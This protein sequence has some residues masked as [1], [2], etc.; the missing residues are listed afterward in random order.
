MDMTPQAWPDWYDGRHINEVLFCQQFLDKHPMKCVRGRLFTVDG[1]IEDEGQ[2]GNLILEEISG[3]LTSGLSKV[4][5]N[6][7][8]SIKLQAY[9]PPLPIEADRIHVANGTYFMDGSF[10][11]NKSYCNNRLTVSYNPD[12]PTPKRWLQFL[13]ELLQPEDIPTLQEFWVTVCCR[14]PRGRRCSCSSARAA[15]AKAASVL[16]CACYARQQTRGIRVASRTCR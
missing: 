16:S 13:S 5:T 2:I 11:P 3:V 4:V 7:L 15:R 10:T 6:L 8:A 1:L 9:S 14:P 12:A